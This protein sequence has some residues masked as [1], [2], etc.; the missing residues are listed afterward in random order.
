MDDLACRH[1]Q[2]Y[3]PVASPRNVRHRPIGSRQDVGNRRD[4]PQPALQPVDTL[5]VSQL[6]I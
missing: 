3:G 4:A 6:S 2:G 1:Q 5:D